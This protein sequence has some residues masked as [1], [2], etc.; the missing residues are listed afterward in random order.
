ME[1]RVFSFKFS[2]VSEGRIAFI[3]RI[4]VRFDDC[5]HMSRCIAV[6]GNDQLENI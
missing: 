4:E 6:I 1:P 5:V 2:K 3:L